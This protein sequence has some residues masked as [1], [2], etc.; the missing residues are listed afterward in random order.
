G[1]SLVTA[2]FSTRTAPLPTDVALIAARAT[3]GFLFIYHGG[4][5][6]FGWFGGAGL[7]A[8]ATLFAHT[9]C[10]ELGKFCAVLSGI[11]E[12]G[13]GIA[14]AIGLLARL[15]GLA[16]F[17]DMMIA[18]ITVEWAHGLNSTG[19]NEG[20]ELNLALGVLALVIGILGAGRVSFDAMIERRLTERTA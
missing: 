11:T 9:A 13:G 7:D 16:I 15:G 4:R 6:L 17:G 2:L 19:G 8:S 1:R 20:Y 12:L 3:I 14:I 10:L 5:R 18:I